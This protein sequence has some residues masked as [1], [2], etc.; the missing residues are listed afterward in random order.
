MMLI[1]V[2]INKMN[3]KVQHFIVGLCLS[4]TGVI[5]CG[6]VIWLLLLLDTVLLAY[7]LGGRALVIPTR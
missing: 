6:N 7:G 2:G 3:D 5:Q 1:K 4:L